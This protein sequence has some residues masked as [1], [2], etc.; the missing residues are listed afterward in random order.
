[1]KNQI[2]IV[3]WFETKV[4]SLDSLVSC[5]N[6]QGPALIKFHHDMLYV[7]P[8]YIQKQLTLRLLEEF[9]SFSLI[10]KASRFG[11]Q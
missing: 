7:V 11:T 10:L 6:R 2:D 5:L 9:I 4:S 3:Y 8:G 1:M